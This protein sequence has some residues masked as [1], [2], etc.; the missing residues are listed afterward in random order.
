MFELLEQSDPNVIGA[1]SIFTRGWCWT[2]LWFTMRQRSSGQEEGQ[3][4]KGG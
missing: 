3:S 1:V 4:D 2:S